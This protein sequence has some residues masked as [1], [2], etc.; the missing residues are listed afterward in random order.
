MPEAA[1]HLLER[2][3][4]GDQDAISDLLTQYGGEVRAS[5][6]GQIGKPWQSVLDVDDVM[7]VTYLEAVIRIRQFRPQ[8]PNAFVAWLK[9]IARN[10]LQDAIR[11]LSQKKRP[12]PSRRVQA[13]KESDAD[14]ELFDLAGGDSVTPSRVARE[15][16]RRKILHDAI[17]WLPS[18][19]GQ[20][21]R[22]YDL[23]RM[24]IGDVMANM[25]RSRGA[26]LM[27]RARA[28]DR[29]RELL[30]EISGISSSSS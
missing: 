21:L 19:Y 8:G 14:L 27:L 23:E 1:N 9:Q 7:Q 29:L 18:A 12:N 6:S 16:E 5:L 25:G 24:P 17:D 28:I 26:I 3:V 4:D 20:V 30:A 11:G 15:A 22:L 2:A 13:T 10:N